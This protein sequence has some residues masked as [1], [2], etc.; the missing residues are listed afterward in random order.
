[1]LVE[2]W[3]SM[4]YENAEIA[5][6]LFGVEMS[7]RGLMWSEE[8]ISHSCLCSERATVDLLKKAKAEVEATRKIS[9]ELKAEM[10]A[11][12]ER[13]QLV[14]ASVEKRNSEWF[15]QF[16]QGETSSANGAAP[17]KSDPY[18]LL[19]HIEFW[20]DHLNQGVEAIE[21]HNETNP[22]NRAAVP[23]ERALDKAL[24]AD[25]AAERS[26]SR[27]MDRL[28]RLQRRRKGEAVPPPLSV[29]VTR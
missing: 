1:V 20:I 21:H 14:W 2:T 22:P 17:S 7:R 25:A 9:E 24:R 19:L 3:A 4:R 23:N 6:E 13:F 28:E 18:L 15:G 27:A 11:A 8:P 10:A 26:L 29:R 12:G 16:L 5:Y